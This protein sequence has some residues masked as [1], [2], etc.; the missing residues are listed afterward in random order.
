[1]QNGVLLPEEVALS[2]FRSAE[3][4]LETEIDVDMRKRA[5]EA[6]LYYTVA[7]KE[8][9]AEAGP[10]DP[11]MPGGEPPNSQ[12]PAVGSPHSVATQGANTDP[13]SGRNA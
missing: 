1:M 2:R 7:E 13:S 6:E 9:R 12:A 8:Q 4:R 3:F 5:L 10:P 11:N